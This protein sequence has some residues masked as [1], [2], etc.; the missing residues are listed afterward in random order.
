MGLSD[1]AAQR[2]N[3]TPDMAALRGDGRD[4]VPASPAVSGV[5]P[6]SMAPLKV[7]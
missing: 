4:T 2:V 5:W 7:H 1:G 3:G 6:S